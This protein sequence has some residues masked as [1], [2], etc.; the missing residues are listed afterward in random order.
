MNMQTSLIIQIGFGIV[1][2][3]FFHEFGHYILALEQGLFPKFNV[4]LG[5]PITELWADKKRTVKGTY[6]KPRDYLSGFI[7]ALPFD[8]GYFGII[9]G[10][11]IGVAS[12]GMDIFVAFSG[13]T[14]LKKDFQDTKKSVQNALKYKDI[15]VLQESTNIIDS[16]RNRLV[17]DVKII[18][19]I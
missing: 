16:I 14:F 10:T 2:H 8:I 17:Y 18:K 13:I 12:A 9:L 1:I 19:N 4:Y 15:L 6:K 7:F 3:I 5:N 11:I